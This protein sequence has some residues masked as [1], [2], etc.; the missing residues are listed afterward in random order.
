MKIGLCGITF[1]SVN[2]GVT[3]LAISQISILHECAKLNGIEPEFLVFSIDNQTHVD[4]ICS[5]LN[6]RNVKVCQPARYKTG[7]KGLLELRTNIRQC[8]YIFDLTKGDSFSDIYGYKRF[9]LQF[10]E[11]YIAIKKSKLIISPQTIGPFKNLIVE[12]V[13]KYI[14]WNADSVFARDLKSSEYVKSLCKNLD[15]KT[16]SDLAFYLPYTKSEK[17]SKKDKMLH[18]GIN[19]SGLLWIGGYTGKNEFG[20]T[21]DYKQFT[22]LLIEKLLSQGN[23]EVTLFGHVYMD[24][25]DDDYCICQE[26]NRNHPTTKVAKKF[27]DPIEAKSFMTKLD[28]VIG[29]RMHS[30]IG[31]I[32]SGTPALPFSYSRKFEGLYDSLDYP[33]VIEATKWELQQSIDFV[34]NCLNNLEQLQSS[35]ANAK[36]K[37]IERNSIYR[38]AIMKCFAGEKNNVR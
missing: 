18:V 30:T 38:D 21:C 29:A 33:Y 4:K 35:A 3:A 2:Y 7:I 13:A 6:I 9:V 34:F 15:I 31:A 11:K 32:S 20:L 28:V 1:G 5:K 10:V 16:T 24:G 26:L 17:L 19:I 12:K 25:G 27:I 8:D 37:A 23:V 36:K 22:N 14:L